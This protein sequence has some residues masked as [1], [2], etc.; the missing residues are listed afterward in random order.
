MA[1]AVAL[2]GCGDSL[3]GPSDVPVTF[4]TVPSTGTYTLNVDG[5][6]AESLRV[7]GR[8]YRGDVLVHGRNAFHGMAWSSTAERCGRS[9][10]SR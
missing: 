6:F 1:A 7:N 9:M 10:T 3:I 8:G 2:T 5:A 4:L